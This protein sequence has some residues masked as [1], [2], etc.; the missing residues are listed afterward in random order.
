[1]SPYATISTA[2]EFAAWGERAERRQAQTDP[3]KIALIKNFA[4][5]DHSPKK[6]IL[7]PPHDPVIHHRDLSIHFHQGTDS[8]PSAP[9]AHSHDPRATTDSARTPYSP[10]LSSLYRR[11]ME[12]ARLQAE[13]DQQEALLHREQEAAIRQQQAEARRQAESAAKWQ[14]AAERQQ[15]RR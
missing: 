3:E 15:Q 8:F 12:T 7:A 11:K 9:H 2:A 13:A 1:M 6:S 10:I 5:P 4:G 14:A